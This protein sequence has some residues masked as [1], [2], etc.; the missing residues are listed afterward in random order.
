VSRE[1]T[2][3]IAWTCP[4]CDRTYRIPKSRPRPA[5]CAKCEQKK[6]TADE[7]SDIEFAAVPSAA[8]SRSAPTSQGPE[9]RFA[10]ERS[11]AERPAHVAAVPSDG[12]T[13]EQFDQMIAHLE[14]INRTMKLFRRFLW[15][16]GIVALL[17]V[18]LVGASLIYGMSM[19][20]SISS[21]FSGSADVGGN[22]AV[23]NLNLDNPRALNNLPPEVR[24]NLEA[25]ENY[26]DALNELLEEAK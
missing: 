24:K 17:N 13:R 8:E 25:V 5:R 21:L 7:D 16:I 9:S 18:L 15:A 2:D 12:P 19:L 3:R 22:G 26:S 14:S 6:K 11:S 1:T 23:Q 20:G 10:V 4:E